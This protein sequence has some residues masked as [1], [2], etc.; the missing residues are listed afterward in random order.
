[1]GPLVNTPIN[2]YRGFYPKVLP[3]SLLPLESEP[4]YTT[5]PSWGPRGICQLALVLVN[6][7]SHLRSAVPI[8]LRE[9]AL[10]RMCST[11]FTVR[12]HLA[13]WGRLSPGTGGRTR[14]AEKTPHAWCA[15]CRG[16]LPP[17][18][19]HLPRYPAPLVHTSLGTYPIAGCVCG[20]G[21]GSFPQFSPK[22]LKFFSSKDFP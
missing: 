21:G 6:W 12:V 16:R 13:G 11:A 20:G 10:H 22:F 1:M 9:Y 4:W 17:R 19:S 2:V 5:Q 18:G 14:A 3:S 15:W 8:T 7:E